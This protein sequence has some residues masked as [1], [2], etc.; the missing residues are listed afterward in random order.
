MKISFTAD[1]LNPSLAHVHIAHKFN[2]IS[3]DTGAAAT[4]TTA[5]AT[6]AA[7]AASST[8]DGKFFSYEFI[9]GDQ[10]QHRQQQQ[11]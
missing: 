9:W 6:T 11:R 2:P 8:I 5:A 10:Q 7:T 1:L 4:A 3:S